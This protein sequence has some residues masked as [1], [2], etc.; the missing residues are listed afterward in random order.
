MKVALVHFWL[1]GMRGGEQVLEAFCRMFPQADIF[2]HVYDPDKVSETIR[3]HKVHTTFINRLPGARKRYQSYFPLMP[4]ALDQLDLSGYD[5]VISSESGPA[6]GVVTA[7]DAVH[8]CYC[9]TP[10]RYVWDMHHEYTRGMGRLKRFLAAPLLQYLRCWDRAMALDP[11]VIVANS[12][13]IAQRVKKCWGRDALVVNPPVNVNFF[14]RRESVPKEDFYLFFGELV[15]Y[16]RADLAVRA[17]SRPGQT[18]RLA[19]V[20][21]GQQFDYLKS[22]AGP[23][24][25]LLGK[26]SHAEVKR[27]LSRARALIFPGLEDFGI[28]PVEALA[29]GTPVIAYGRGGILDTVKDGQSGVFF[30]KQT[31]EDLLEA[32]ARF[33][34]QENNFD[35]SRLASEAQRFSEERFIR[36]M[37]EIIGQAFAQKNRLNPFTLEP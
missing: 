20:G 5:L 10:M 37:R 17:F 9:H 31:E 2:T 30:S 8:I 24:V 7:P 36:E 15:P 35:A 32:V 13:F 4:A 6:K 1:L 25:S 3:R 23:Q 21:K 33:E 27:Y 18:R 19:V 12:G 22:I 28:I 26:L 16:K 29:S 14:A 34:E 11:D